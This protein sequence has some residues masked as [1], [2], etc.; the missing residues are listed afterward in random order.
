MRMHADAIYLFFVLFQVILNRLE[1][2]LGEHVLD[3]AA[4]FFGDILRHA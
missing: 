1:S 2:G 4:I 3:K